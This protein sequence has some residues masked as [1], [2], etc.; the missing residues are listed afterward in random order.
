V[1]PVCFGRGFL[2]APYSPTSGEV[3]FLEPR[4]D[5]VLT[6]SAKGSSRKFRIVPVLYGRVSYSSTPGSRSAATP[7][8]YL[9]QQENPRGSP[10]RCFSGRRSRRPTRGSSGLTAGCGDID[11]RRTPCTCERLSTLSDEDYARIMLRG[12]TTLK[13]AG[14]PRRRRMAEDPEAGGLRPEEGASGIASAEPVP[15]P[16]GLGLSLDRRSGRALRGR[17]PRRGSQRH[18]GDGVH[19]HQEIRVRQPR[20]ISHGDRRRVRRGVPRALKGGKP[21]LQR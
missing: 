19:L 1:P 2:L 8:S 18:D 7:W 3:D 12:S 16:R 17:E 15:L 9:P 10:I 5:G 21:L 13:T 11:P 4:I 14:G 6:S 20:D